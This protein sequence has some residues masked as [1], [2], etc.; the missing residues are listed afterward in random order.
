[1]EQ[2]L[3]QAE[4]Q[5]HPQAHAPMQAP[6]QLEAPA[7]TEAQ[8]QQ[9]SQQQQQQQQQQAQ[10]QAQAPAQTP[11][12]A[13]FQPET[14]VA[15]QPQQAQPQRS[16]GSDADSEPDLVA[17]LYAVPDLLACLPVSA[18]RS[19]AAVN[20][21]LREHARLALVQKFYPA[22][23]V[24]HEQARGRLLPVFESSPNA[25][26]CCMENM[27]SEEDLNS[28]VADLLNCFYSQLTR[29][30]FGGNTLSTQCIAS[31]AQ[32]E[33]PRLKHLQLK[34]DA[35]GLA[36]MQML[37]QADWLSLESLNLNHDPGFY[38]PYRHSEALGE[39]NS[40]SSSTD[41]NH[42]VQGSG[43]ARG[44]SS[45]FEDSERQTVVEQNGKVSEQND[46]QCASLPFAIHTCACASL[47]FQTAACSDG[48]LL[49]QVKVNSCK[50][51]GQTSNTYGSILMTQ[52][53][54]P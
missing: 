54:Q 27:G 1:M 23:Q 45:S 3:P 2:S 13:H 34:T 28:A 17:V 41:A 39:D 21:Q 43:D 52:Y 5:A 51:S 30:Q 10:Q 40:E 8:P 46:A 15:H 25:I 38:T 18:R 22:N 47:A 44:R 19:L 20:K 11:A 7:E 49:E 16:A 36:A 26:G 12:P 14:E 53:A 6:Q 31:T 32:A 50:G 24:A 35:P 9:Q 42:E 33:W 4:V 29:V 37:A 48:V